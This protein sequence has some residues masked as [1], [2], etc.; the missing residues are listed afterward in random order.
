MSM[1][2]ASRAATKGGSQD[3]YVKGALLGLPPEL[4]LMILELL[5]AAFFREDIRRL[6]VCRTWFTLAHDVFSSEVIISPHVL[7]R[8]ISSVNRKAAALSKGN[9]KSV[10]LE[11][12]GRGKWESIKWPWLP[13]PPSQSILNQA[14]TELVA[15]V[16]SSKHSISLHVK[17]WSVLAGFRHSE[18]F[19]RD[20]LCGSTLRDLLLANVLSE[21]VLDTGGIRLLPRDATESDFHF[22]TFISAQLA[23]L[24]R[25]TLRMRRIC[26]VAL[27]PPS[28]DMALDLRHVIVN[29]SLFDEVVFETCAAYSTR[30][31]MVRKGDLELKTEIEEQAK[32]LATQMIHPE[33]VMIMT[34]TSP[35]VTSQSFDILK[36]KRTELDLM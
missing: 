17:A 9:L 8:F 15:L 34:H 14:L 23:N 12:D 26:P 30:C 36:N 22:C 18:S 33:T 6:T 13:H 20:Y 7:H 24:R 11:V 29:L 1:F 16:G 21:L 10:Y 31:G 19:A 27:T 35:G 25:L 28:S 32:A 5:G 4:L 3:T 2:R